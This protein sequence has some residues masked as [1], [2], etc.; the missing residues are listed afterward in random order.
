VVASNEVNPP[1]STVPASTLRVGGEK[2]ALGSEGVTVYP[3][4]G[5]TMNAYCPAESVEVPDVDAPRS[6]IVTP[7]SGS[8][9][10]SAMWPES[11]IP[12]A[13][14]TGIDSQFPLDMN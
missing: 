7:R 12:T 1:T 9:C 10:P 14:V 4:F 6:S 5:S 2:T 13:P 8:P 3:L 11:A